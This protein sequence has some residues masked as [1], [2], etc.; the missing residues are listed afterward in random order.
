MA[1]GRGAQ[2]PGYLRPWL[3]ESTFAD[4]LRWL[5]AVSSLDLRPLRNTDADAETIRDTA[6][7][8][9]AGGIWPAGSPLNYFRPADAYPLIGVAAG[10]SVGEITAAA[11]VEVGCPA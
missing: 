3:T 2:T 6:V 5:S 10:R 7:A 11:G 1:P 8:H 9:P 4:R